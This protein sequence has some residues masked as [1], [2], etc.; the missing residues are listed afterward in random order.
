MIWI[1]GHLESL[2]KS[3][4]EDSTQKKQCR[5]RLRS[6]PVGYVLKTPPVGILDGIKSSGKRIFIFAQGIVG[7]S[8]RVNCGVLVLSIQQFTV[9]REKGSFSTEDPCTALSNG[10]RDNEYRCDLPWQRASLVPNYTYSRYE[11]KRRRNATAAIFDP[12]PGMQEGPPRSGR[13]PAG[14]TET[15]THRHLLRPRPTAARQSR[16]RLGK[17]DH[18]TRPSSCARY[19][20]RHQLS[21]CFVLL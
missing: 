4:L 1:I 18:P 12:K 7:Y 5:L 10:Q 20:E 9:L 16:Q 6:P 3:D 15:A 21:V 8:G 2:P 14:S 19:A 13:K 11:L 17:A